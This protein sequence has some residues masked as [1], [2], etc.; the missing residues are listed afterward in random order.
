MLGR[1][2]QSCRQQ[3]QESAGEALAFVR[4][5]LKRGSFRVACSAR[6]IHRVKPSDQSLLKGSL[7]TAYITVT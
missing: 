6:L 5:S 7:Q 1:W 4:F 2:Q 3:H